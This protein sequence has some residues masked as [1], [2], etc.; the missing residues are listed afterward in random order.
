[1]DELIYLIQKFLTFIPVPFLALVNISITAGWIVLA[2]LLI[3]FL[4]QKAPKWFNCVLWGIVALRLIFPF[5]VESV[6]SL[7]PSAQTI[8]PNL[9]YIDEFKINSGIEPIDNVVNTHYSD[10]VPIAENTVDITIIL[11]CIWLVGLGAMLIYAFASWAKLRRNLRTST[12]KEGN[13]Y[14]SEFVK[15]PFV[16]GFIK[17][18][19]YIPYKT[20]DNDLPLVIA[21]EQAH[22]KR[23]DHLIKP[24]GFLLLSVHWFNPLL[25][26][27]YIL[28]CR[29]IESACDEKVVK[30]LTTEQRKSYSTALLNASISR[31]SI[32]ACP[33]AFGETGVK[34][35]IKSVMSYKK[36]AFWI[37]I[38]AVIVCIITA[39]CFLT[40]PKERQSEKFYDNGQRIQITA[41]T[42]G[43]VTEEKTIIMK[44]GQN[45][46]LSNGTKFTV[47]YVNLQTGEITLHLEGTPLENKFG[48]F[49]GSVTFFST[50]K[51]SYLTQ[52]GKTKINISCFGVNS[53]DDVVS[54]AIIEHNSKDSDDSD[55]ICESHEILTTEITKRDE[56]GNIKEVTVYIIHAY[57]E[58]IYE[59]SEVVNK[60]GNGSPIALIFELTERN[61]YLLKEYWEPLMGS[62][63]TKS[64]RAKFPADC[65]EIAISSDNP[66]DEC[67]RMAEEHYNARMVEYSTPLTTKA[68]TSTE[69]PE[70]S[71][72]PLESEYKLRIVKSESEGMTWL[73]NEDFYNANGYHVYLYCL[74]E[75]Y[76]MIRGKEYKI[77]EALD[78]GMVTADA[79]VTKA[80]NDALGGKA[81]SKMYKDGGSTVISYDDGGTTEYKAEGYAVIKKNTIDGNKDVF[82]GPKDMTLNQVNSFI[83]GAN[84][85]VGNSTA[86]NK[87]DSKGDIN[88]VTADISPEAEPNLSGK[89]KEI[90]DNQILIEITS[91]QNGI[92]AGSLVYVGLGTVLSYAPDI[93]SLNLKNGDRIL[94]IYDG[95]IMETYPY[96]INAYAVYKAVT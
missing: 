58:Y 49:P 30:E 39:V 77:N 74:D 57:C 28:L 26:I 84:I 5:S 42:D 8:E 83:K 3:R 11:A 50:D 17:P 71:Y 7:I 53:L 56:N 13:I 75:C 24:L 96:Q 90:N 68:V 61:H 41:E 59:N 87:S 70:L 21:H 32:A 76:V 64:I 55:Y 45:V 46:R 67:D 80:K 9:P 52:D 36:P 38:A 19:I 69:N 85:P 14:Q 88:G 62:G 86:D 93:D 73:T 4:F 6:F 22:I 72:T 16:L 33:L 29:D 91:D 95:R 23:F 12:K 48:K 81:V 18:K 34:E 79:I 25:W 44:E 54:K 1:M 43:V 20:N 82:I 40:N 92:K 10:F 2:V 47:N 60:S 27:A 65:A 63:Y 35:R 31:K 89:I 66:F 37:V 51:L 78:S 15:S 94:V